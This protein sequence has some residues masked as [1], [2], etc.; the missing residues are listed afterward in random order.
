MVEGSILNQGQI[1]STKLQFDLHWELIIF[2]GNLCGG[3]GFGVFCFAAAAVG[4]WGF[5]G[6]GGKE[7]KCSK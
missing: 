7:R 1:W 3:V 2:L 4:C 6:V 5:A